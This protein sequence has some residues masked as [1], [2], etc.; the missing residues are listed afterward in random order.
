MIRRISLLILLTQASLTLAQP[1]YKWTEAD[2]SITFSPRMPPAGV[3]YETVDSAKPTA[4]L[5][6]RERAQHNNDPVEPPGQSLAN[7]GDSTPAAK[8]LPRL[9]YAPGGTRDLPGAISRSTTSGSTTLPL[10]SMPG[11][12]AVS[13]SNSTGTQAP[14]TDKS[15]SQNR[16]S[17]AS[18]KQSRCQDLRKRVTSL[19]RRLKS[20]LTP[21][22]MDNTIIHM[23]R[24]QRSF[25][26][27]CVQ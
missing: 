2:G 7:D 6:I 14:G 26:Q 4:E 21:E 8:T 13:D 20:R 10:A 17:A 18:Y 9:E 16:I 11:A 15:G 3:A 5:V 23:A 22:D 27:H 24:Y 1:L 12:I 19:E 25:D